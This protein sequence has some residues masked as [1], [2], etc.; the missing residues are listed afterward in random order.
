[1][2]RKYGLLGILMIL[3]AEVNFVL[4]IQPYANWYFPIIWFGYI[5]VIDAIIY[6]IRGR[7]LISN[8]F[9]RFLG[10]LILSVLVWGFIFELFNEFIQNWVY[11]R[12]DYSSEAAKRIFGLLSF[13]TVIPAVFE[14]YDLIRTFHLF[15][16]DELKKKHKITKRFLHIMMWIGI[17]FLIAP[18]VFPNLAFPLVWASL[19]FL[20]DP[21]NYLHKQPSII[22]HLKD[23]KLRIPLSLLLAGL[24]T[25]FFWEF[26]N[27]WAIPKWQYAV[28]YVGFFKVFEMPILGYLGYLPFAWEL[29]AV[30]YFVRNLFLREENAIKHLLKKDL[31]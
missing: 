13:S 31:S 25:G 26:W 4:K 7:S 11:I 21:I 3:F 17:A 23:R 2:F 10:L 18:I 22:S 14:T 5:L 15:D 8:H 24:I 9:H 27:Y 28:P 29:Y 19:F 20:L 1:M 30:Y 6:K 16:H 12:L